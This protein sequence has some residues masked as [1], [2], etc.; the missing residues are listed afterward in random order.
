MILADKII[1]LRKQKGWSQEELAHQLDVSR[2]AVSKWESASAIPDLERILKMSQIFEVSTDYLLKE[3]L[4]EPSAD[5]SVR[6]E[7]QDEPKEQRRSVSLA[8]VN[9][10]IEDKWRLALP[11]AL[12]VAAYILCPEV[13]IFL[14]GWLERGDVGITEDAAMGMGLIV[15]LIIAAGATVLII[16]NG[17]RMEKYEFL[18]QGDFQ[19]QYGVESIVRKR[20][21]EM[22]Q[23]YQNRVTA[24]IFLC[25]MSVLPVFVVMGFYGEDDFLGVLSVNFM[26][27]LTAAGVMLI[28]WAGEQ[29]ETCQMLLKE[30]EFK[31]ENQRLRTVLKIYWCVVTA[32]YLGLSFLTNDWHRTWIV[33]PCAGVLSAAVKGIAKKQKHSRD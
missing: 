13:L 16:Q 9:T 15:L 32:L 31:P 10:F 33:W 29:W 24:G 4:E 1:T 5:V 12:A 23:S 2:Q 8:E 18:K 11:N 27:L 28:V 17:C 26:L 25:I 6:S 20:R 21:E 22:E 7:D 14:G 30:G 3:E 19:L